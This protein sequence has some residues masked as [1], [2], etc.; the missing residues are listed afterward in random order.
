M[1]KRE[2]QLELLLLRES[3]NIP[4]LVTLTVQHYLLPWYCSSKSIPYTNIN[5]TD[6]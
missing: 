5:S 3:I 4:P 1:S 6:V 2:S